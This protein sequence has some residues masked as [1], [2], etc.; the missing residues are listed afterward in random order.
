[1]RHSKTVG[2][3]G[4]QIRINVLLHPGEVLAG[5]L[6][7]RGEVRSAFAIKIGMYPSHFSNLLKG[8]RDI[9][10]GIAIKLEEE[11]EIPA[12]FWLGLQMDYDLQHE[13]ERINNG[14][15]A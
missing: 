14:L 1:M 5:E 9:S 3:T 11:L 12:E 13:R 7:A 6:E 2:A 10:A 15:A 8:K 4:E